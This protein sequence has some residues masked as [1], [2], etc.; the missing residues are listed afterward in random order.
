MDSW[1]Q[2]FVGAAIGRATADGRV[3]GAAMLGAVAATLPDLTE[4][5]Y[6]EPVRGSRYLV[7]HRGFTHSL[8]GAALEIAASTLLVGLVLAW[9]ARGGHARVPWGALLAL[10]AVTVAS[11]LYM[12]WQGSYG[13]R[14]FLPWSG[15]W[16]YADWVAIVDPFFW[17]V[18]LIALAW[19]SERHWRPLTAVLLTGALMTWG[20]FASV[21]AGTGVQIA[22]LAPPLPGAVGWVAHWAGVAARRQVA[23]L[24]VALLGT[25]ALAS[26]I[27]AC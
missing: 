22:W 16:Y 5:L 8:A 13:L 24:A 9:R 3:P 7:L 4:L 20:V 21:E 6:P 19:G 12:D 25:Y 2:A 15:R 1:A 17:L 27:A 14:P 10:F 23:A 11:H 26:R 18:P